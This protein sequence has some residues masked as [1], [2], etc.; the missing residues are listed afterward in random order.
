MI[1][2]VCREISQH[3]G[4]LPSP[5]LAID[6]HQIKIV[7]KAIQLS[8]ALQCWLKRVSIS[9]QQG[10]VAYTNA[11]TK[12][13]ENSIQGRTYCGVRTNFEYIGVP[14]IVF[15]VQFLSRRRKYHRHDG[16]KP[17]WFKEIR[18]PVTWYLELLRR[19]LNCLVRY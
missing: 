10:R 16:A 5:K 17:N 14:G 15:A 18:N 7:S 6:C 13:F 11:L 19:N 4:R 12:I 3:L 1:E 9:D 2:R 8:Y